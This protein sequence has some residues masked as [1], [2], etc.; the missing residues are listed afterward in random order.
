MAFRGATE[1]IT[2]QTHKHA[3]AETGGGDGGGGARER[4]D[5]GGERESTVQY[6]KIL[7]M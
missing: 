7:F 2:Q 1:S 3:E 4:G 6:A 5:R